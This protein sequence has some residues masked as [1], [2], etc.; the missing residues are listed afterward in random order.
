MD[1][2][3]GS[4]RC[5][6]SAA[7]ACVITRFTYFMTPS[8]AK[9]SRS[10]FHRLLSSALR[11]SMTCLAASLIANGAPALAAPVPVRA[12][13]FEKTLRRRNRATRVQPARHH[14]GEVEARRRSWITGTGKWCATRRP[15]PLILDA[16]PSARRASHPHAGGSRRRSAARRAPGRR[17]HTTRAQAR[18]L[19]VGGAA[20]WPLADVSGC[21]RPLRPPRI[22]IRHAGG[23]GDGPRR[24]G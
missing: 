12:A 8:C 10:S 6:G 7:L 19:R 18:R 15:A 22:P 4:C 20:K 2:R 11:S 23:R 1:S 5:A 14:P 13:F 9:W 17:H 16:A 21:E 3:P 24:T